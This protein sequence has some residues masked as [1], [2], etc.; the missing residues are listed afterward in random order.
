MPL[1][2]ATEGGSVDPVPAL[3]RSSSSGVDDGIQSPAARL[4]DGSRANVVVVAREEYPLDSVGSRDDKALPEYFGRVAAAAMPRQD[5]VADVAAFV[6][7]KVVEGVPDRRSP[8]DLSCNVGHKKRRGDEACR[9]VCARSVVFQCRE[10]GAPGHPR[11]KA[12]AEGEPIRCHY[13]ASGEK[14]ALIIRPE[15]AEAKRGVHRGSATSRHIVT[16]CHR[17]TVTLAM[18]RLKRFAA[19]QVSGRL[20][21][22]N[23]DLTALAPER[24]SK[25]CRT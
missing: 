3:R 23:A 6:C 11:R 4:D 20:G 14:R 5:T 10:V 18:E 19:Q 25:H 12:E 21:R 7:E 16:C 15:R 9:Q 22:P 1:Y 17:S 24:V 13:T 8:D 2:R